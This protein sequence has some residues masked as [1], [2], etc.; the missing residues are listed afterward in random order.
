MD[1]RKAT[2]QQLLQIIRF[3]RCHKEFKSC[4]ERELERRL[5]RGN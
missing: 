1:F 4:A 2:L 5:N 3:E